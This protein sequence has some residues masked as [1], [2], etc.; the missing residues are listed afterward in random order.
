M[1]VAF[2][3]EERLIGDAAMNQQKKNYKNTLMFFNRFLGLNADCV[4]QLAQEEQF[5]T[6][7]VV[8][9][10]NKKIAFKV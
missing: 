6:Y 5:T 3:D 10:E 1:V 2:T 9:L 4:D 8:K 7:E